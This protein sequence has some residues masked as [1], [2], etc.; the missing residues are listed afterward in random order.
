MKRK[1]RNNTISISDI[2]LIVTNNN[3]C[4]RFENGNIKGSI[5]CLFILFAILILSSCSNTKFLAEDE[6]LYTYTWFSEKGFGK[7]EDKPLK[8]LELYNVGKVK[9]NRPF[10]GMPRLNLL[11]YNYWK[12]TG[13]W[14]PRHYIYRVWAK[15]PVLLENVNPEFRLKVMQQRMYEMGHFDSHVDLDIKYY[16]EDN[17]KARAKYNIQFFPAYTFRNYQFIPQNSPVDGLIAGSFE[18][19]LIKEGNGYWLNTLDKERERI[20][21]VLRN[22]GYYY[23]D[24]DFLLFHADTT[25]VKKRVDLSL[26]LKSNVPEKAL[27]QYT[28]GDVKIKVN[29]YKTDLPDSTKQSET[30]IK[31]FQYDDPENIFHAKRIARGVSIVPGDKYELTNQNNTVRFLQGYDV[32]KSVNI[33]FDQIDTSTNKLN[34]VVELTPLKPVQ[35]RLNVTFSTKSNDFLGPAA[36]VSLAHLNLFKGAERLILKVDGGFEWQKRSKKQQYDLGFNSYEVG[37]QLQLVIPRVIMPW[38]VKRKSMRYVSKTNMS[39]GYRSLK[40]VQFYTMNVSQF[41]YGYTWRITEKRDYSWDLISFD[42][43]RTPEMS[44]DFRLFLYYFPQT[45]KSFDE[46]VIPGSVFKYTY[47]SNSGKNGLNQMYFNSTLDIAGNLLYLV[48][49]GKGKAGEDGFE[50]GRM[51]GVP[52]AQYFKLNGDFR[53]YFKINDEKIVATRLFAGFGVPYGNSEVLPFSKNYFAGGSQDIRAFYARTVGP[54]SYVPEYEAADLGFVDQTGDI[55][56][57]GNVEFR[58]PITYRTNGALFVDAG[59]VWLWKKDEARPG[60]EFQWNRFM[61]E[62]AIG[63]GTGLR[64]DFDYIIFRLD[65]AIPLRKPGIQGNQKWIFHHP[66]FFGDYILS[67]AVGYPF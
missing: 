53:Y 43:L 54:G 39:V 51:L 16:G 28:I 46:Q 20:T 18:N 45:A 44:E 31:G 5:A 6:K 38:D 12:P 7:I 65:A 36:E 8:A 10:M 40:R 15:P 41:R 9:T 4:N 42:Y 48:N 3:F 32:F 47:N 30:M 49:K 33:K 37:S 67:L 11:I 34:A 14:G 2:A 59:N 29:P 17:K 56:L 19:R 60:G 25:K 63:A 61:N 66:D 62:F 23:F 26:V 13:T 27:L 52:Y 55:K 50:P 57:L 58:F 21:D 24:P 22:D 35:T 64:F 1:N